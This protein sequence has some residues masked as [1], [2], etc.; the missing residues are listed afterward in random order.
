M[1]KIKLLRGSKETLQTDTH[2]TLAAGSST[3]RQSKINDLK[4][5]EGEESINI[6][7]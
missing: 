3:N 1:L 4:V 2:R 7:D 5:S 6:Q